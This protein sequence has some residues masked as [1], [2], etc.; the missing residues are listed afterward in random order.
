MPRRSTKRATKVATAAPQQFPRWFKSDAN[1]AVAEWLAFNFWLDRL[2]G[3]EP[4]ADVEP[5]SLYR[6]SV[7]EKF[8]AR[9]RN[10]TEGKPVVDARAFLA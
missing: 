7:V 10:D 3:R 5:Y 2:R 6:R 8:L 9:L 4:S 1:Q